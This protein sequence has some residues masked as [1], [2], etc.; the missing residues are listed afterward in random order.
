MILMPGGITTSLGARAGMGNGNE[1]K[2]AIRRNCDVQ[3]FPFECEEKTID[4]VM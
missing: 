1:M 3:G 4:R 2:L